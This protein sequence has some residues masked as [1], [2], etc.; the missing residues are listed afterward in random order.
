MSSHSS[1][2]RYRPA[3]TMPILPSS[4]GY[5]RLPTTFFAAP[6][7]PLSINTN[8]TA[9]P[10]DR[11][12]VSQI[13]SSLNRA[14]SSRPYGGATTT[15]VY[16]YNPVSAPAYA[17]P[18]INRRQPPPP[19]VQ[20]SSYAQ[21]YDQGSGSQWQGTLRRTGI[22]LYDMQDQ[23]QQPQHQSYM[24]SSKPAVS[25]NSSSSATFHVGSF[26]KLSPNQ[27]ASSPKSPKIVNLQYNSP[28]GL[29]SNKNIKEE[30]H[31]QIG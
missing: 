23:Q 12:M 19:P 15:T 4:P 6:Q 10:F 26:S 21:P 1:I 5:N 28:I 31:K 13:H 25:P 24:S 18:H 3:S 30:L 7:Q 9:T 27:S 20:V 16:G 2:K 8:T 17:T 22:D 29:Y 14:V 11:N